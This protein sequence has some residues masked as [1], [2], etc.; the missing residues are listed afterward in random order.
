MNVLGFGPE[1]CGPF[2]PMSCHG[3]LPWFT[4]VRFS[5][6]CC[7]FNLNVGAQRQTFHFNTGPS[8]S[9]HQISW[10]LRFHLGFE[11]CLPGR[12]RRRKISG[13]LHSEPQNHPC[14]WCRRCTWQCFVSWF[15]RLA[16]RRRD[17]SRCNAIIGSVVCDPHDASWGGTGLVNGGVCL[18]H[19]P[20]DCQLGLRPFS[21][22]WGPSRLCRSN[23]SCHCIWQQRRTAEVRMVMVSCR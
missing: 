5:Q 14:L 12:S 6:V 19:V 11:N 1:I 4:S 16:G 7:T 22:F 9:H 15:L 18:G 23:R 3:I 2:E 13:M 17:W 21:C 20:L 10:G 8:L